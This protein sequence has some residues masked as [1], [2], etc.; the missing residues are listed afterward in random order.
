M[1][2]VCDPLAVEMF[3]GNRKD[4]IIESFRLDPR[5]FRPVYEENGQ[6][7]SVT[8]P[9][10]KSESE[11]LGF[12]RYD[13]SI[14][15]VMLMNACAQLEPESLQLGQMMKWGKSQLIGCHREGLKLAAI[16]MS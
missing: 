6:Q 13:K 16:V 1:R 15:Q 12:I 10:M 4:A 3:T 2:L 9:K 11:A 5:S 8:V 14:G 7:I